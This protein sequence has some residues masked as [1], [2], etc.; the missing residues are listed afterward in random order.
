MS[1][2]LIS[3]IAT[4]MVTVAGA[5]P[6][7]LELDNTT[8]NISIN[9]TLDTFVGSDSDADASP[10]SGNITIELDDYGLPTA[11][12]IHDFSMTTDASLDFNFDF[13][14]FGFIQVFIPT[15]E[16]TYANPGVPTGPVG[17]ALD[18][19]FYFPTIDINL[20]GSGT[21]TGNITGL[22]NINETF[23]LS[24]SNPYQSDLAGVV[25]ITGDQID[26]S[27]I[28]SFSGSGDVATGVTLTSDG[29]I[30]I[31]AT[32]TVPPS[33]VADWNGDGVLDFFDILGFLDDFSLGNPE[34]DIN[35]DGVIDFFDIQEFLQL[36][37][38]GCP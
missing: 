26:F 7:T 11:I 19:S 14:F 31:N 25:T 22:G 6:V 12:S 1:K 34:A 29:I 10:L 5:Q 8:S 2:G 13:G 35:G 3:L 18:G 9:A 33:C 38:A 15:V 4:S 21:A 36:F 37:A 28:I 27:G 20:A 17:V 23:N 32:G 24:D 16:A 30:V